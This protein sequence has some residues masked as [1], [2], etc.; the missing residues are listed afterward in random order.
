M[1]GGR[2]FT[3]CRKEEPGF[4]PR[5]D[6]EISCAPIL[7]DRATFI[8]GLVMSEMSF[9]GDSRFIPAATVNW[10][11]IWAGVFSFVAIWSVF[12]LLGEAI[13]ASA[14]SPRAAEPI[15]GMSVGMSIWAVILTIIAMYIAGRVTGHL[16]G[17][18]T[19]HDG[20]I[21]GLAMFGL[22]VI[23]TIVMIVL[24]GTA[25]TGTTGVGAGAHS[26]YMLT[27]FADVGWIGFI[28]LFLGWLAAMG[29]ASSGALRESGVAAS[30]VRGIR[31]AA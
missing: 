11:A 4:V 6:I 18:A 14:A 3:S 9:R 12:G 13:F 25:L 22:A 2:A 17:V 7:P 5:T 29:G 21:H 10:G 26:A 30:N 23:S 1:Y 8:G 15:A 24:S 20:L 19:R 27:V 31:P 16:A 28:S